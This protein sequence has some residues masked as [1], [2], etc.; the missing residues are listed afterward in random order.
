MLDL[1]NNPSFGGA[2]VVPDAASLA[3]ASTCLPMELSQLT[4]LRDLRLAKCG[5]TVV[6]AAILAVSSLT[7]LDLHHN[8]LSALP[9]APGPPIAPSTAGSLPCST[10]PY[11]VQ[12]SPRKLST[13]SGPV[14]WPPGT[15][16]SGTWVNG[17]GMTAVARSPP[18]PGVWSPVNGWGGAH[19]GVRG[20]PG[21]A[22]AGG[23]G[24]GGGGGGGGTTFALFAERLQVLNIAMNRFSMWPQ[25]LF[26]CTQ[27]RELV[28][29][30]L[31]VA[32]AAEGDMERCLGA[33]PRLQRL[34]VCGES[35]E[36]RAVR[37]LM[38][39]QLA[40]AVKRGALRVDVTGG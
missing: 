22:A 14:F 35:F 15:S 2:V 19:S 7:S 29:G 32:R 27:L 37:N 16:G 28:V 11:A 40:A 18:S 23:T 4:G 34:A 5:L 1:S 13:S 31:L 10:G 17:S 9:L 33:L 25:G 38:A 8:S 6:P 3:A 39:L 24:Y 20:A 30:E 26:S 36:P 21:D 12:C